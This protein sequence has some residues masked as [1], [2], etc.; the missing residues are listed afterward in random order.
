MNKSMILVIVL[1]MILSMGASAAA[2]NSQEFRMDQVFESEAGTCH[3]NLY[4][5]DDYDGSRPYALH[6]ALPGWEG[7]YFQGVGEDLRWEYLPFESR[8]YVNDMIVVSAQLNDWGET[9]A[10]QAVALTEFFLSEYNID[11]DRVFITGYS[12]GGET[13]SRVMELKPELYTAALFVSSQWDGDLQPLVAARTPLYLFTAEHDSY[14]GSEPV[15]RAYQRIHDLYA[16]AGLTDEEIDSLLVMDIRSDKELDSLREENADKV[17]T[18]YAIDYH[19]AGMLAAFDKNVMNWVFQDR[20][21]ENNNT[22]TIPQTGFSQPVPA[23]YA[24]PSDHPGTVVRVDYGS[25]DYLAN[26]APVVKTAYVYLPY[27]YDENDPETRYDILYLM[28]GWTG[29]AGE[30]FFIGDGMIKNMLDHMIE[31]GE[32]KPIIAVSATFYNDNSDRGFSESEDAI[33][34]FHRDFEDYLMPAVE[35]TFHTYAEDTSPESLVASRDHRAFGGFSLGS[36]TTWLQFCYDADYIHYFLPMSGSSWY[37]GTYG[38]FQI[39]RNV[40]H[41]EAVIAD[42]NLNERGYFIYHGVGTRDSVRSQSIMMAEEMLSRDGVFPPEHYVFYQKEGGQHDHF[43]VME[44]M[45]N[46]LPLFFPQG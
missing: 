45:F 10:R 22:M 33:R 23:V 5:P 32:I 46:A 25:E 18:V 34:E 3:Y 17:G 39:Q 15:R 6:I 37:Y 21:I 30:Y 9:S 29:T 41:I 13:L 8:N 43:A 38:D 26:N 7:L 2:D 36:V 19:G 31:N 27:G 35:G 14:Y 12:G 1:L 28:H 16:E 20:M 40:D 11:P 42:H 4:V 24:T 44:F